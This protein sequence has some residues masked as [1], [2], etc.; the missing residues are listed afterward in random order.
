MKRDNGLD[1]L[2]RRNFLFGSAAL[3]GSTSLFGLKGPATAPVDWAAPRGRQRDLLQKACSPEKLRQ[4]LIPRDKYRPFPTIHDRSAWEGLRGETRASFLAN[5]EKYLK[6]KWP[7][8]PATVFL[9]Y[10][11]MGNRTDYQALRDARLAALQALVYAECVEG[12]GRF[13]DDITNGVWAISEE[14]F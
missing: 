11:R 8:M 9:E 6:F 7:E 4:S 13:L 2:S 3:A 14:S 1:R 10:A 12:K 5:G